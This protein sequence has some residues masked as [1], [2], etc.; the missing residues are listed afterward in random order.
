MPGTAE[1]AF[2]TRMAAS[3]PWP[4]PIAVYGYDDTFPVAGDLFEAETTCFPEHNA[5]QV[6]TSGVNN[7]AFFSRAPAV[8]TP[9]AQNPTPRIAFN[10]SR[11]YMTFI[12]GDGDNVQCEHVTYCRQRGNRLRDTTPARCRYQGNALG[13]VSATHCAVPFAW[14]L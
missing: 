5:G 10:A 1:H 6:A 8:T 7:L 9:L 12:V 14:G 11:T 3:N 13:L 2:V 4:S